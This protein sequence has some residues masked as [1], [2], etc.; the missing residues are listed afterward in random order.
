MTAMTARHPGLVFFGFIVVLASGC[1]RSG[2]YAKSTVDPLAAPAPA[3]AV[4]VAPAKPPNACC[5]DAACDRGAFT[6]SGGVCPGDP[7][8]KGPLPPRAAAQR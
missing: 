4:R 3:T 2:G 7:R 8:I 5:A 1:A 6:K